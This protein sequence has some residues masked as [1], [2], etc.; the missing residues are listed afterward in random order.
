M[1]TPLNINGPYNNQSIS[2]ISLFSA[3]CPFPLSQTP[4]TYPHARTFACTPPNTDT[5]APTHT[6]ICIHIRLYISLPNHLHI[7]PK[8]NPH[9]YIHTL[10]PTQIP[11]AGIYTLIST[12][13]CTTTHIHIPCTHTHTSTHPQ[14]RI[15]FS[16]LVNT[17]R[18]T[19]T[20]LPLPALFLLPE[21][22]P[23]VTSTD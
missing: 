1:Q 14:Q 5:F 3:F 7:N 6:H 12:H 13:T 4:Q 2:P 16:L 17:P 18:L 19:P 10:T 9:L 23:L 8:T 11:N 15:H 20:F 22:P 21:I